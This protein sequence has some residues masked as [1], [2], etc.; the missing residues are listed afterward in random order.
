MFTAAFD[1]SGKEDSPTVP[2]LVVAGFV[3]TAD[4]WIAF[5]PEWKRRLGPIQV[6]ETAQM[7][8]RRPDILKSLVEMIPAFGLRKF[9][10]SINLAL[11]KNVPDDIKNNLRLHAYPLCGRTLVTYVELWAMKESP[12]IPRERIE[13]VFE[14]GD[15]DRE[16][17]E[18][19]MMEDGYPRP[20]FRYKKDVEIKGRPY[21]GF[22]PLQAADILA[23][24]IYQIHK[25]W[26]TNPT[27]DRNEILRRVRLP[28]DELENMPEV[29][30][31]IT[32][33]DLEHYISTRAY[34]DTRRRL[35]AVQGSGP[36]S[37]E[38]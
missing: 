26:I 4:G 21:K 24:H 34:M 12:P 36:L 10:C 18:R 20:Q 27:R 2:C 8:K 14:E 38:V 35:L 11:L 28:F 31:S 3:G 5:E 16:A 30:R 7:A 17:L 23:W 13:Y 33:D 25:S 9:S 1:A 19:L 22:V 15:D 6:W 32:D 37:I 29:P